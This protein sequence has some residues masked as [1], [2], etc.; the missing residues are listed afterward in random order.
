MEE[1]RQ[2]LLT[3]LIQLQEQQTA[4][5]AHCLH[6]VLVARKISLNN[7]TYPEERKM[8]DLQSA[9]FATEEWTQ[10]DTGCR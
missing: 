2:N 3:E 4:Q 10:F 6:L 5:T 1:Y 7:L 9:H 8:L